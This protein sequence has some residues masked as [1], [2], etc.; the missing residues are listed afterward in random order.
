MKK[1][2]ASFEQAKK[3]LQNAVT[4]GILSVLDAS[5][6]EDRL[7]S[8]EVNAQTIVDRVESRMNPPPTTTISDDGDTSHIDTDYLGVAPLGKPL[9]KSARNA[10]PLVS[11][12]DARTAIRRGVAAGAIS[13]QEAARG[14]DFMNTGRSSPA[15]IVQSIAK[16]ASSKASSIRDEQRFAANER[17]LIPQ[18]GL[19]QRSREVGRLSG[20]EALAD[21]ENHNYRKTHF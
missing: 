21:L 12:G 10:A 7:N 13:I 9:R 1:E 2:T 19:E 3:A 16:R 20:M 18:N 15:E 11:P 17:N 4:A 14:E 8:G 5:M 6:L